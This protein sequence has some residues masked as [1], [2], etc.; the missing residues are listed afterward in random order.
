MK[1][2]LKA[3]VEMGCVMATEC[4]WLQPCQIDSIGGMR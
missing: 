1:E 4:L 3:I 2:Y